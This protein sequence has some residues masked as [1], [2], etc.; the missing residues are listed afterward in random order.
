MS[1]KCD[2]KTEV[3]FPPED[4]CVP[5]MTTKPMDIKETASY[6]AGAVVLGALAGWL[7]GRSQ[8]DADFPEELERD[9]L[10]QQYDLND[11]IP[12]VNSI[13]L[14][15]LDKDDFDRLFEDLGALQ[16][17]MNNADNEDTIVV[18]EH[19]DNLQETLSFYEYIDDMLIAINNDME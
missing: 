4:K 17:L 2:P 5:R 3:Y 14:E 15:F 1:R 6:G 12:D 7:F 11:F 18:T 16:I 8:K 13:D 9:D 10:I 19:I